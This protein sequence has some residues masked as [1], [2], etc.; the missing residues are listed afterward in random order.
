MISQETFSIDLQ[1]GKEMNFQGSKV[2]FEN[3]KQI[4]PGESSIFE[5]IFSRYLDQFGYDYEKNAFI[6]MYEYDFL[7]KGRKHKRYRP[8]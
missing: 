3:K 4:I 1:S 2:F 8:F 7:I 5:T 6:G